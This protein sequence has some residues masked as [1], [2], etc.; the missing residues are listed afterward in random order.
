MMTTTS[1][2][3]SP[4]IIVEPIGGSMWSIRGDEKSTVFAARTSD[5]GVYVD[6]D[7]RDMAAR[8]ERAGVDPDD[9]ESWDVSFPE[10][11]IALANYF[12]FA[13]PCLVQIEGACYRVTTDG[14]DATDDA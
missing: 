4:Q 3:I 9:S 1:P 13:R 7:E 10:F 8:A 12:G 5:G 14:A 11:A 6:G 2:Q